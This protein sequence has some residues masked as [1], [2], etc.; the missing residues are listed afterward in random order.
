MTD[1]KLVEK[2]AK[3]IQWQAG[4][5]GPDGEHDERY[6]PVGWR[7]LMPKQRRAYR[8]VARAAIKAMREK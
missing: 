3:A 1:A 6:A 5:T 7:Q 8:D 4:Q 2:V